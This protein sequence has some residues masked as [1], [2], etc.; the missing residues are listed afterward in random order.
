M[1]TGDRPGIVDQMAAKRLPM[2]VSTSTV[3]TS[4]AGSGRSS[5]G[6]RTA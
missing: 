3:F 5:V 4:R 2:M 6:F 1:V